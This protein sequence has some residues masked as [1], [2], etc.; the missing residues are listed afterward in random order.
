M[1][2]R[3]APPMVEAQGGS[4]ISIEGHSG[5]ACVLILTD[6]QAAVAQL[7][8]TLQAAGFDVQAPAGEVTRPQVPLA[9]PS[10]AQTVLD[11]K[12]A[13]AAKA[14]RVSRTTF[15]SPRPVHA[16]GSSALPSIP[17]GVTR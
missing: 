1:R 12:F 11:A 5:T 15:G 16:Q 6:D 17:T 9:M 13:L 3:I 4:T 8:A 2:E 10:L 14:P 7:Y